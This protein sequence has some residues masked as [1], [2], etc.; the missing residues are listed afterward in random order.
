MIDWRRMAVSPDSTLRDALQV[1]NESGAQGA[2]VVDADDR[3]VGAVTDGDVRRALLEGYGLDRPVRDCSTPAPHHAG[4]ETNQET[5]VRL[6]RRLGIQQLP[7]LDADGRVLRVELIKEHLL[8]RTLQNPVLI[9]AGGLGSR[10]RPLTNDCPK[11]LLRMGGDK[12]IL[13]IILERLRDQ[14]FKRIYLSV[15]Y[16]AQMIQDHFGDG[17]RLELDIQYLCENQPLGT[18]GA[19]SLLPP[20]LDQPLLVMN[21]DLLTAVDFVNLLEFHDE[22][23]A[24]ATMCVREYDFQVP[25]GVVETDG[26][27]LTA[28]R[29]KPVH[30]F[31]INA[32]IYVVSPETPARIPTNQPYDMTTLFERLIEDRKTTC[33]YP[34]REMW[35]DIGRLE[36]YELAQ[37]LYNATG[38][39]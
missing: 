29:E 32:G 3:L 15:N 36:D 19:L 33:A 39:W 16:L 1:I 24:E 26:H 22:K 31:Y 37:R 28:L 7:I 9:M 4:P 25:Y 34:L 12:P 23:Q 8:T 5:A 6:M 17:E 13:E 11:P 21:G 38:G 27:Q 30:R 14:G 10:L 20:D 35:L 2:L 18:A